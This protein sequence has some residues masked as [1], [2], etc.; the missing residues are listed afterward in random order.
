MARLNKCFCNQLP[1]PKRDNQYNTRSRATTV[2]PIDDHRA[3]IQASL[4]IACLADLQSILGD[5][6]V[7][8]IEQASCLNDALALAKRTIIQTR[9]ANDAFESQCA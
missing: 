6:C 8:E 5:T 3:N 2:Q 4:E 7:E 1:S 9:L